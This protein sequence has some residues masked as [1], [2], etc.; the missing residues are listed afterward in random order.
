M[1]LG[2]VQLPSWL[3]QTPLLGALVLGYQ[4]TL[5]QPS[6]LSKMKPN[7]LERPIR[8]LPLIGHSAQMLLPLCRV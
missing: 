2:G 1:A 8:R 7:T 6:R 3:V 5:S 4:L